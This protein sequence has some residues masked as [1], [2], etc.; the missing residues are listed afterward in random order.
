MGRVSKRTIN[1]ESSN[2]IVIL[3]CGGF[4]REMM[5]WVGISN[6]SAN[7]L[8]YLDSNKELQ[9]STINGSYS[10]LGGDS[11]IDSYIQET[12]LKPMAVIGV[13]HPQLRRKIYEKLKD[14]VVFPNIISKDAIIGSEVHI[15]DNSGVIITPGNII[16]CNIKIGKQVMINL[17]CTIGHDCILEDFITVSPGVNVS[18]YNV[19]KEGSYLGTGV[20]TLEGITVGKWSVIGGCAFV[21][22]SIPDNTVAVGVPAKPI[23]ERKNGWHL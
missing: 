19:I 7:R 5:D 6:I 8:G 9:G 2:E 22:R 18:G 10:V 15:E 1:V 11:W 21:N 4:G 13:G 20:S 14:K 17:D 3:G 12:N 23:K 16:S